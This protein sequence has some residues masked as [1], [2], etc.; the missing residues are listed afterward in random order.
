[1]TPVANSW[2]ADS[3]RTDQR[4]GRRVGDRLSSARHPRFHRPPEAAFRRGVMGTA[5]KKAAI[6]N[7]QDCRGD[8]DGRNDDGK[9]CFHAPNMA[10]GA[11]HFQ[12]AR[13]GRLSP[14]NGGRLPDGFPAEVIMGAGPGVNFGLANP[15]FEIAGMLVPMLLPRRGIIHSA[16]GAGKFFGGPDAACHSAT[17]R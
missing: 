5:R 8:E 10:P 7:Q 17:M 13:L 9:S 16:T 11:V 2:P 6:E 4:V 12:P 3:R 15:A 14:E 1:M